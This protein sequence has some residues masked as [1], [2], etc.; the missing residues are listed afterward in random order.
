M[1][2]RLGE[3][4]D[5]MV[6]NIT[7]F[8]MFVELDNT[9]EGLVKLSSMDDDYYVYDAQSLS[10]LGERTRKRFRIGDRV[11]VQLVKATPETRQIDFLLLDSEQGSK[12]EENETGFKEAKR[13]K[14]K[15]TVDPRILVHIG[16]NKKIKGKKQKREKHQKKKIKR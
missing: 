8:G 9:I 16:A 3:E 13:V 1:Q 14:P 15:K 7:A 12:P 6:S 11:R 5:G 10:L 4:F 2:E